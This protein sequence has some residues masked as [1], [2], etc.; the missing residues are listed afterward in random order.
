M[1]R[2]AWSMLFVFTLSLLGAAGCDNAA[3]NGQKSSGMGAGT[4]GNDGG[5]RVKTK[6]GPGTGGSGNGS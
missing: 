1:R 2:I 5:G 6:A 3:S 4:S